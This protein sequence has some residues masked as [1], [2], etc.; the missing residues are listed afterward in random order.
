MRRRQIKMINAATFL[1]CIVSLCFISFKVLT[2]PSPDTGQLINGSLF[3]KVEQT[4]QNIFPLKDLSTG[5][6]AVI[7]YHFFHEGRNG[8]IIGREDWLFSLEE[9]SLPVN[10]QSIWDNNLQV[11]IKQVHQLQHKGLQVLIVF[12]PEKVDIY[13]D[14]LK[15]QSLHNTIGLYEHSYQTLTE[16]GIKVIDLR[17]ALRQARQ[18]GASVFFRT[19]THW[20]VRS[21]QLAAR[22]IYSSGFIA[23]GSDT[24]RATPA[25]EISFA[26]DLTNFI[27]VG[28]F[29]SRFAPQPDTLHEVNLQKEGD[30]ADL[31]ANDTIDIALIG[32]SYSADLR[33]RFV[34]WIQHYLHKEVV[35]YAN[36]G[37]G[38]FDPMEHFIFHILTN[39]ENLQTVIWEIPVRYLLQQ[40]IPSNNNQERKQ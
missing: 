4:Y 35:N 3:R 30:A 1:M 22:E 40:Y 29:F 20:T 21:A 33:W 37:S 9:Y 5:F 25:G 27:P 26:G 16:N 14:K 39:E 24:F 19:D 2:I 32:T 17:G 11:I 8:V 7:N 18:K 10:Y 13:K 23:P 28:E 6:W 36:K 12:I 38:P 15:K 31:F 34:D